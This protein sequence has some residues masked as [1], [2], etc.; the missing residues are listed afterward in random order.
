MLPD[1]YILLESCL[2][3][4]DTG[5]LAVSQ[6]LVSL[7]TFLSFA[8]EQDSLQRLNSFFHAR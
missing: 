7:D 4:N 2:Y 5:Q 1:P 6:R 3:E 8:V